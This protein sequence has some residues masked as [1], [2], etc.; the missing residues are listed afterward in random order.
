MAFTIE[1]HELLGIQAIHDYVG[2]RIW[3]SSRSRLGTGVEAA[4]VGQRH[5]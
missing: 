2:C 4:E 5:G 3:R 1:H